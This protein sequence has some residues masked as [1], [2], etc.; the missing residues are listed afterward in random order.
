MGLRFRQVVGV[1]EPLTPYADPTFQRWGVERRAPF[2][3]EYEQ[4]RSAPA[5]RAGRSVRAV[6]A[7]LA[8]GAPCDARCCR[9][10][11]AMS[12]QSW[13]RTGALELRCASSRVSTWPIYGRPWWPL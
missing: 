7:R 9:S 12:A 8:A 3:P 11:H 13:E 2:V 10:D 6:P 1:C 5:L 4:L